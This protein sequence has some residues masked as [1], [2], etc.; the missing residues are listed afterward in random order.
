[1]NLCIASYR[2]AHLCWF[3]SHF[4]NKAKLTQPCHV[5]AVMLDAEDTEVN[6]ESIEVAGLSTHGTEQEHSF[7][8]AVIPLCP[9]PPRETVTP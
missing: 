6:E 9:Q 5:P 1:M 8:R 4:N 2:S 3:K 7:L